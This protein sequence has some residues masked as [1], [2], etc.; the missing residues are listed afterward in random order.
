MPTATHPSLY[1]SFLTIKPATATKSNNTT[2]PPADP[3]IISGVLLN[4]FA[5]YNNMGSDDV[6]V[7]SLFS[8]TKEFT[9]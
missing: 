5:W 3:P 4:F 7:C 8:N 6:R 9:S 2:I 1:F